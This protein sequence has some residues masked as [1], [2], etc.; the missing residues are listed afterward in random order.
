MTTK[1]MGRPEKEPNQRRR[2][3]SVSLTG[4]EIEAVQRTAR[5]ESEKR[6]VPIAPAAWA[7]RAIRREIERTAKA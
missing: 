4:E 2:S 6:G 5:A 7:A 1:K 3:F